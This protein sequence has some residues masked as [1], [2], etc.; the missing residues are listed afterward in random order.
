MKK[1][2]AYIIAVG[3]SELAGI[4]G[5]FFTAS[6]IPNWYATLAKPA[7]N[8]PSWVF[9]PVW[10]ILYFLMGSAAFLIWNKGWDRRDV[11]KALGIFVLQLIL[12]ALWSIILNA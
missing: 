8:P 7:L 9:G 2:F 3:V 4:L 1:I 10:T 6:A 11:K 5:S 12:N